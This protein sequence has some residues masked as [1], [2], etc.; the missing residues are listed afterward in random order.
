ML[1]LILVY[2][3]NCFFYFISIY[4][5]NR[6]KIWGDGSEKTLTMPTLDNLEI[7]ESDWEYK[8]KRDKYISEVICPAY[9]YF[10]LRAEILC[11]QSSDGCTTNGVIYL[12]LLLGL[13][14][15]LFV[16]EIIDSFVIAFIV[17]FVICFISFSIIGFIYYRGR[18][19]KNIRIK[20]F[21]YEKYENY[22][23]DE[24]IQIHYEYLLSI[25][26]TVQFRAAIS[27]II[28][29]VAFV[30]YIIFFFSVPE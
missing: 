18:I 21:N 24:F 8:S 11:M 6:A 9:H 20:H 14:H 28:H 25:K 26:E 23:N 4:S 5:G 22:S 1:F 17:S 15:R 10:K 12:F 27:Q 30:I 7:D 13:A 16:A 19:C 3:L 2:L 29:K